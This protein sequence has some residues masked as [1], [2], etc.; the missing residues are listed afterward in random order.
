MKR[1]SSYFEEALAIH[2]E[3]GARK[4]IGE[5]LAEI[6]IV[7]SN[8]GQYEKALRYYEEALAI[9]K[10]VGD[11]NGVGKSFGNIGNIVFGPR[12]Q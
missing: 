6:G 4:D 3:I 9:D 11:R 8:L 12:P 5:D 7:Y 2:K 10:E 1:R